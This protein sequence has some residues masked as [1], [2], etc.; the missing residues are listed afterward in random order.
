LHNPFY[1]FVVDMSSV[2]Y[3]LNYPELND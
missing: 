1:G 3:G 2:G